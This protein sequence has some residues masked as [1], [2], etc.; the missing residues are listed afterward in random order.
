MKILRKN[1]SKIEFH[2]ILS[3]KKIKRITVPDNDLEIK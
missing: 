3:V 2:A 1:K